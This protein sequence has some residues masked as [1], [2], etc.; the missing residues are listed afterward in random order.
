MY[1]YDNRDKKEAPKVE[2]NEEGA[3]SEEKEK[4]EFSSDEE[5]PT[6]PYKKLQPS[7][8]EMILQLEGKKKY[9]LNPTRLNGI[10]FVLDL[11][12][13]GTKDMLTIAVPEHVVNL[14]KFSVLGGVFCLNLV[15][16][17]PQPQYFVTMDL[18]ITKCK[19]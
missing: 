10:D 3:Q 12:Y 4:T 7:A 16:Q 11:F 18:Q 9:P 8:S 15:Y 14:R 19:S 2:E 6:V 17:P 1:K 13:L 5:I